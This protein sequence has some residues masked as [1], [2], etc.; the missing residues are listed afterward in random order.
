M[1]ISNSQKINEE[2]IKNIKENI[3]VHENIIAGF[4]KFE[5]ISKKEQ[6]QK[7]QEWIVKAKRKLKFLKIQYPELFI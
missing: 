7:H 1:K 5:K 6:I 3:L 2:F 4:D